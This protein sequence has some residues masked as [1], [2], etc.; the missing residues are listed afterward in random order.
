MRHQSTSALASSHGISR[1]SFILLPVLL[2]YILP[3][4]ISATSPIMLADDSGFSVQCGA[5]DPS[6]CP[7]LTY[8][9]GKPIKDSCNCCTVCSS[10]KYQPH[11]SIVG[12]DEC[13]K[14]NCPKF[15]VCVANMQGLPL[16]KCPSEFLCRSNRKRAICGS[17]G[18]TYESKCHMRIASCKQ[19]MMVRKK[20][21]GTCTADDVKDGEAFKRKMRRRMR[22]RRRKRQKMEEAA[23]GRGA[24]AVGARRPDDNQES[25]SREPETRFSAG[26]DVFGSQGRGGRLV[27]RGDDNGRNGETGRDGKKLKRRR[28]RKRKQRKQRKGKKERRRRRK[29]R[30]HA[31]PK[32]RSKRHRYPR[33]HNDKAARERAFEEAFGLSTWWA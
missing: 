3:Q 15:Q 26:S 13:E 4:T 14:V 5:C 6:R 27:E 11:A 29:K 18:V 32:S 22:R 33:N 17:D 10:P 21:R 30:Q 28:K 31:K 16:C 2:A 8:C 1:T 12:G 19:G 20:H 24:T 25:D 23:A 9:E 7:Q